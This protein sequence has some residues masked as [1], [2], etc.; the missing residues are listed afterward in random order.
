[1][2]LTCF[3]FLNTTEKEN[4]NP[5]FIF[6]LSTENNEIINWML[7]LLFYYLESILNDDSLKEYINPVILIN[8][9]YML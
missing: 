5:L 2:K 9:K 8:L 6:V 1:M 7:Y 3:I 4:S